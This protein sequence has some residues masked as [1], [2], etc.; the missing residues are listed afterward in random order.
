MILFLLHLTYIKKRKEKQ[1]DVQRSFSYLWRYVC[2]VKVKKNTIEK[3]H[4]IIII[5]SRSLWTRRD[6]YNTYVIE[7]LWSI[8]FFCEAQTEMSHRV[9]SFDFACEHFCIIKNVYTFIHCLEVAI[10]IQR[11]WWWFLS[12]FFS[13]Q[14]YILFMWMN[15]F[16]IFT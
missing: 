16:C 14:S 2:L 3:E 9:K 5:I 13:L 4:A 11:W 1:N 6:T 12:L 8:C 10:V 15:I 7:R